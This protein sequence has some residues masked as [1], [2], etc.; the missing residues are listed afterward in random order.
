MHQIQTNRDNNTD[1]HTACGYT[2]RLVVHRFIVFR[3][4]LIAHQ[5]GRRSR[6]ANQ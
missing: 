1:Q 2:Y 3:A 6:H 4:K 5:D